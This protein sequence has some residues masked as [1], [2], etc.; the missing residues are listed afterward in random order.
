V[1]VRNQRDAFLLPLLRWKA[2]RFTHFECVFV[3]LG[4]YHV[5]RMRL[6]VM[7]GLS[8]STIF[9]HFYSQTHDFRI[10]SYRIQNVLILS[11]APA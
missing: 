8:S 3:A 2:L 6:I 1:H 7:C 10:E 9:F 4:I 11:T 5:M